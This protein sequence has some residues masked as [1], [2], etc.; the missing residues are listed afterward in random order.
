MRL[1]GDVIV[2]RFF[3]FGY[4]VVCAQLDETVQAGGN[5]NTENTLLF[6]YGFKVFHLL[7]RFVQPQKHFVCVV[8]QRNGSADQRRQA[9]DVSR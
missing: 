5:S 6:F 8:D 2:K 7:R 4:F 1:T 3:C 9:D